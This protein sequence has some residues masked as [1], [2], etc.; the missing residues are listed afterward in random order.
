MQESQQTPGLSTIRLWMLQKSLDNLIT[1]SHSSS[2]SQLHD[3][4]FKQ[5]WEYSERLQSA[6]RNTT[7]FLSPTIT[8]S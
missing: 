7:T 8:D 6:G 1:P 5:N 2:T 4:I 3:V